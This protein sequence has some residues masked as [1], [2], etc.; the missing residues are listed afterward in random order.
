MHRLILLLL[1]STHFAIF[2]LSHNN[3]WDLPQL[4]FL[5]TKAKK[6][7]D[8]GL[9]ASIRELVRWNKRSRHCDT[10]KLNQSWKLMQPFIAASWSMW[11]RPDYTFK[12]RWGFALPHSVCFLVQIDF[13]VKIRIFGFSRVLT[14]L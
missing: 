2:K 5:K 11:L 10:L 3:P 4:Q 1:F 13:C 6:C 7:T 14:P 12:C 9:Q 8:L